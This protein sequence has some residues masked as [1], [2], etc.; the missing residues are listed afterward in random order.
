MRFR[1][2]ISRSP[3]PF[4]ASLKPPDDGVQRMRWPEFFTTWKTRSKEQRS[5]LTR[6]PASGALG[7]C[8]NGE[9][10]LELGIGRRTS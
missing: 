10:D 2:P 5:S 3:V 7:G 4:L 8:G 9:R 6:T 1:N